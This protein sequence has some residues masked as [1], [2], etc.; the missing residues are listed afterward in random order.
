[1]AKTGVEMKT[2]VQL[3]KDV[4]EE[5][6]WDPTVTD[7]A[8]VVSVSD[9]IVTLS[10]TVPHYAEKYAAE[11]A[12]QRVEGVKAIAEEM[13]VHIVGAYDRKDSEIA[14]AVV[15][16]L[17]WH[18]WV[19][20]HVHATVENGWVTLRGN[21]NWEYE[22]SSSQDAVSYLAGVNGV[23]NDIALKP[24]VKPAAVK[25]AIEKALKR[26]AEID[27]ENI[28]VTTDGGKV[29]LTGSIGSWDEREEAGL[30]AWS[31]PGVTEVANNLAIA[32]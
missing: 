24:N 21:V 9:G 29:T 14:E 23:T 17:K 31:A 15:N 25:V 19:P 7:S 4:A 10:G 22:R 11:R 28:A 8:I 18:V 12:T 20:D 32:Y 26:D 13:E 3:K 2:D 30:A 1:L 5:L 6:L 16:S 27:A